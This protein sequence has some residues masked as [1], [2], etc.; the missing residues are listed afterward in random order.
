MSKRAIFSVAALCAALACSSIAIAQEVAIEEIIVTARKRNESLQ[1]IPLS[2]TALSIDS[3]RQRNIQT[4]Y[5]IAANTP[6]YHERKQLGRR[7]DHPIIRGQAGPT[8]FGERNA[9]YFVDGVYVPGS[10]T[11]ST[12]A[13][14]ERVEVI[15]G[16]Q[17]ALFGRAT[18]SGAVNMITR[19]ASDEH[20][21]S[22]SARA[23]SH[24]DY[25]AA[26]WFSGPI[27][28]DRL[29]YMVSANWENYGG[30]WNNGLLENEAQNP[31]LFP[32]PF[33]PRIFSSAP[34][35]GDDS[36]LG[37]ESSW[38]GTLRL[39]FRPNDNHEFTFK[40][41]YQGSEDDHFA[42]LLLPYTELNC[43]R[44]GD[45][46]AGPLARG[47][48]CGEL[49]P[50]GRVPKINIPDFEDGV[51][52]FFGTAEPSPLVGKRRNVIRT[53]LQYD[54]DFNGWGFMGRYARSRDQS[55]DARDLDRSPARP[56]F[57]LFTA[58][59][60]NHVRDWSFEARVTSPQDRALRVLFGAYWLDVEAKG[61]DRRFTGP[62]FT[63]HFFH[64]DGSDFDGREVQNSAVFGQLEYD[65]RDDLTFSVEG[66]YSQDE[67]AVFNSGLIE[68]GFA[69][70]LEENTKAFTP[71]FTLTYRAN[72]DVTVYG[73]LAKGDKPL[74]FNQ[75][76]FDDDTPVSTIDAAI[77]D[78]RAIIKEEDA[79]TYEV[80]VKSTLMDGRL[81]FNLS[82]FF[83]DWTNQSING[84]TIIDTVHGPEPNNVVLTVPEAEVWGL[85]LETSWAASEN[86]LLTLGY[87]LVDHE[88]ID[89]FD[90]EAADLFGND[91]DLSGNTTGG[92]PKRTLN[93]SGTYR[94]E[95]TAETDWFFRTIVNYH[96]SVFTSAFNLTETGA[97]LIVNANLGIETDSWNLT[98]YV[99]N[100]LDDDT[101]I[102]IGRFTDFFGPLLPNRQNAYQF[103]IIPRRGRA[104]GVRVYYTF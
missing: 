63:G 35:R 8:V 103:G 29:Y 22:F 27:I 31:R 37:G 84:R 68:A 38:D 9:S 33:A 32:S 13:V 48:Y 50:D 6:N 57:G 17:S 98:L 28:E 67:K 20:E 94:D 100:A 30:E 14:V 88:F 26:A 19:Q 85:E 87:G 91:G 39:T 40:Y 3:I 102:N 61:R 16:P 18:F 66:R 62:G 99:D 93:A 46:G 83:I 43:F 44:P 56:V 90:I 76:F 60:D 10:I 80:G 45:P 54:G 64:A 55:V 82:G 42:D 21:G 75:A 74:D 11:S 36:P 70:G 78:G 51:T 73:L 41:A 72:D 24:E 25:Q 58:I 92:T 104:F 23:G 71:R 7:L 69:Q 49:D 4:I 101:P 77:A 86:L 1:E 53:Y 12:F 47:Y 96:S 79:W 5:D 97:P 81:L 34:T 59:E 65:L 15:R 52:T 89:F 2:V 95:L